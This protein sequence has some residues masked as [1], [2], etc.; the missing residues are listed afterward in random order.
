[1]NTTLAK[2]LT[3][4]AKALYGAI[5]RAD[6]ARFFSKH[7][8]FVAAASAPW[9]AVPAR[10]TLAQ[11]TAIED[12]WQYRSAGATMPELPEWEAEWRYLERAVNAFLEMIARIPGLTQDDRDRI[13]EIVL[14]DTEY[15]SYE[16][17]V[18]SP[19]AEILADMGDCQ[20]D[21]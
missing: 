16:S 11:R 15:R 13:T 6:K 18:G 8:A 9:L 14:G 7:A 12:Q 2:F 4:E 20:G 19:V 17:H 3:A 1:M 21:A 5:N 10:Y